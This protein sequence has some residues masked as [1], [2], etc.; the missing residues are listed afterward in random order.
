MGLPQII[1]RNLAQ[2]IDSN[3]SVNDSTLIIGTTVVVLYT[4]P[5]GKVATI[6]SLIT[7]M[8]SLGANTVIQ[9]QV[10]GNLV[11]RLTAVETVATDSA[12]GGIRMAAGEVIRYVGD[13]GSDNGAANWLISVREFDV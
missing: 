4:V 9:L 8:S 13:S 11:K 10:D 1:S 2:V 12:G 3:I 7:R 5:A 6:K